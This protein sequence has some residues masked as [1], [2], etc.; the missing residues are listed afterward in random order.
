[1]NV[2]VISECAYCSNKTALTFNSNP[3]LL[4]F[5]INANPKIPVHLNK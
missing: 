1:M 3:M 4:F 5:F 2:S